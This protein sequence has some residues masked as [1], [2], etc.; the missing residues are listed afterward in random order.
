M[1]THCKLLYMKIRFHLR[2]D[3]RNRD[4]HSPL[5][6]IVSTPDPVWIATGIFI[7]ASSWDQSKQTLK[8]KNLIVQSNID[9]LRSQAQ[10]YLLS[11]D[12]NQQPFT[13]RAFQKA[14]ITGDLEQLQNPSMRSL[15][16]EYLNEQDLSWGRTRHYQVLANQLEECRPA[17]KLKHIDYPFLLK[18]EA[19]LRKTKGQQTNTVATRMKQIKAVVH[20]AM[21]CGYIKEDPCSNYKVRLAKSYRTALTASELLQLQ[22][23]YD[24]KYLP[25]NLQHVLR[26]FLFSC[27][28][29]LR[30]SDAKALKEN[31]ITDDIIRIRMRKTGDPVTI[32]LVPQARALL[33]VQDDGTCIPIFSNQVT[34]RY[35]KDIGDMIGLNKSL[36]YH[37][38]RHTFASISLS[39]GVEIKTVSEILGHSSVK[40]TELYLHLQDAMKVSEMAKWSKLTA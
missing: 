25:D 3:R 10:R 7:D 30:F 40:V 8:G 28:T 14:V 32:P 11:L 1:Q 6:F 18:F 21:K 4:G 17:V 36:T 37:V 5:Y 31:S 24:R 9:R 12:L 38:A 13:I 35:L 20:Y 34:N 27:Y 26:S 29:G 22:E 15:I 2:K 39:L 19:Y 16:T 23:R 33:N